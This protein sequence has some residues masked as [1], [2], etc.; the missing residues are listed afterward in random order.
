MLMLVLLLVVLMWPLA[1]S[2]LA[3]ASGL[4]WLHAERKQGR[5]ELQAHLSAVL[6]R[7]DS[8][9]CPS[10]HRT[11]CGSAAFVAFCEIRRWYV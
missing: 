11:F 6:C 5:G 3:E 2:Q 10:F 8:P 1:E 7:L 9:N 4:R